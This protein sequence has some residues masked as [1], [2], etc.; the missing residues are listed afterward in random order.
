MVPWESGLKVSEQTWENREA[1]VPPQ[2]YTKTEG[3]S[4]PCYVCHQTYGSLKSVNT[5]SDGYLQGLYD[6]SDYA[7]VNHWENL[8]VDRTKAV[9]AI[10]D[11][12]IKGYVAQENYSD[13]VLR[14]RNDPAWEGYVPDIENLESAGRAFDDDGFAL[15]DSGWVAFKYKPLPSIFWPTNG[16]I[17]DVMIRLPEAFRLDENGDLSRD[18]YL[19]NLAILESAIKGVD[20]VSTPPI[21]ERRIGVDLNHD[22]SFGVA[23]AVLRPGHYVGGAGT[24]PVVPALYPEGTEFLHTVRYLG[25]GDDGAIYAPPRMKEI[26]YMRK[27]SFL[28]P[29]TLHSL[30]ENERQEKLEGALPNYTEHANQGIDNGFGWLLLGFIEDESGELR[31]QSYEEHMFCMGCHTTIGASIDQTFSFARKITG[32]AGWGY[33]DL[34]GMEDAPGATEGSYID[35][36]RRVGAGDEFRENT[37]MLEKWFDEQGD[38][39]E[40]KVR[41]ADVYELIAPSAERALELNKAYL[42]IVKNQTFVYGREATVAPVSNV[43]QEVVSGS[44]PLPIEYHYNNWRLNPEEY[45]SGMVEDRP[46]LGWPMASIEGSREVL[47]AD[48][49]LP[50][51]PTHSAPVEDLL[52]ITERETRQVAVVDGDSLEIVGKLASGRQAH[53][54][55]FSPD[56][57]T[58]YNLGRDGWLYKY[59]LFSLKVT[60]RVR[61]GVDA[62]GLAISDDGRFLITGVF[63]PPQLVILDATTLEPIKVIPTTDVAGPDGRSVDARACAV[64]DVDPDKV[65][66]YFLVALKEAGQVWRIDFDDPDFAVTRVANIGSQLHDGFLRPDHERFFVAAQG[67]NRMVAID[68]ASMAISGEIATGSQPHPGPGATWMVEGEEYAVTV[69]LGEGKAT[70]WDTR[71]LQV[72]GEVG[73]GAGGLD[74]RTGENMEYVWFDSMF[75]PAANEIVVFDKTPPFMEVARINDGIRTLHPEPDADGDYVFISDWDDDVVRVYDDETLELIKTL[76]GF[77][78]P[79]G[80]FSTS[81]SRETLGQ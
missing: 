50:T 68:V 58:A 47:V 27:S 42:L 53:G 32:K 5:M 30:Y 22:G 36:F 75:A 20:T 39:R 52:L 31:K 80:I 67:S 18:V 16:S 49:L 19:A 13:L 55:T 78:W 12:A 56:R 40:D 43:Y 29:E 51:E 66:P 38:L 60:A 59:D 79:T 63:N 24:V 10:S 4:N 28:S 34:R 41:S 61:V 9:A 7:L 25:V 1:F 64:V 14:L 69:H 73:A 33:Q 17:D 23:H 48:E 65:G 46:Y 37:E 81:R 3:R 2:C 15:D 74:V 6:F 62:R 21:D 11:A 71:S 26:R 76:S 70:V 45:D 8:F 44:E 72:V 54:Y 77:Q 35:Y 57:R